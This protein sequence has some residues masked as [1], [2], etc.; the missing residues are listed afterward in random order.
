MAFGACTEA[1]CTVAETDVCLRNNDPAKCPNR[2]NAGTVEEAL[3]PPLEAPVENPRFQHS[4]TLDPEA[5][6]SIMRSRYAHL[7][8]ILGMPKSGKTAALVSTYLLLGRDQLKGFSFL[9]SMSLRALDEIS[10]GARVWQVGESFGQMTVHTELSDER[11]PGF[12]HLRLERHS[13]ERRFDMLLSDLPGEWS[14]ALIDKERSDRLEFLRAADVIW[15]MVDGEELRAKRHHTEHRIKIMLQRLAKIVTHKPPIK[16]VISRRDHGA[17]LQSSVDA[18]LAEAA[19][20]GFEATVAPIASFQDGDDA[21]PGTGIAE[22]IASVVEE[23]AAQPEFWP[24]TAPSG[25]RAML[26]YRGATG[27]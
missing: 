18:L 21:T 10:H 13:D 24:T 20:H 26:N 17:P 4:L 25:A 8:G 5:A 6:A 2:A 19:R 7:V 9:D 1:D 15:I 27:Q 23:E 22:L 3:E 14:T 16:I 11:T 12:M